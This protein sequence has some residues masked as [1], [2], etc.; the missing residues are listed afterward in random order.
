MHMIRLLLLALLAA[1]LAPAQT[2]RVMT[3][4]VRLP[5]ASDGP[6]AWPFRRD[7]LVDTVRAKAPDLMGTQELFHEQG[8][9][10]AENLPDYAWFG[11]SR[12]GNQQ[13]EFMGVF[14]RKD[15]L[16]LLDSGNFWLS[17]TPERPG[18]ISWNMSLPR[19]VT[20]GLF[21]VNGAATRFLYLNT[22]LAHRDI[23]EAARQKSLRL[24]ACRI[25]LYDEAM[26]IVLTGDFNTPAGGA[27]YGILSPLLKD[28]WNHAA[29]RTGP[30]G[31]FHGFKGKPGPHRIDWIMF[32]APWQVKSAE[33]I[34][35]NRDGRYPSDHFPVLAVFELNP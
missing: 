3:F 25:G 21:Q 1:S 33:S 35:G 34:T 30:E 13:D 19:M 29:A 14:Y 17:E 23:D 6:D 24:I 20:W 8:L 4:N 7:L 26:P 10:I 18:S 22:H 12:R 31:T 32:R 2:L 5:L 11:V 27:S 15:R 28:A 9:Y 16:T